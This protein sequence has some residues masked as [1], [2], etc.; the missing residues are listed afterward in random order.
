MQD[1][2][3]FP[4]FKP[5]VKELSD[6]L[7][8]GLEYTNKGSVW[9]CSALW[10]N[11]KGWVLIPPAEVGRRP[12]HYDIPTADVAE[13]RLAGEIIACNKFEL[14]TKRSRPVAKYYRGADKSLARP[15]RKQANV[16][17]RMAWIYFGAFPFQEKQLDDSSRLDVFEIAR[18]H[19]I[20][21][22]LF[23]SWSG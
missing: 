6:W 22:S 21:P 9:T 15:G 8:K 3:K 20:L 11:L 17:V 5:D 4:R 23:P 2:Y 18:V 7:H 10:S 19:D 13:C 16:S 14:G 12:F 1:T